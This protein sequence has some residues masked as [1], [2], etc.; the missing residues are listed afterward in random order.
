MKVYEAGII[1]G[2]VPIVQIMLKDFKEMK[3]DVTLRSALLESLLTMAEVALD[4][5]EYLEGSKIVFSIE[6]GKITNFSG[7]EQIIIAY[8]IVEKVPKFE[9]LLSSDFKPRLRYLLNEFIE[10]YEGRMY[11]EVS[12]YEHFKINLIT[13]FGL[14][15]EEVI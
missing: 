15:S 2:S 7:T 11:S 5:I 12:Q 9:K 10:I 3:L 13:T 1:I 14:L 6:S 4:K 8:A